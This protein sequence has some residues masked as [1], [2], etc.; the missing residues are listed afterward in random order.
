M[1]KAFKLSPAFKDVLWGGTALRDIYGM[2]IPTDTTGEAF[3]ASVVPGFVS[4]ADGEDFSKIANDKSLTGDGGFNLLFKLID[5]RQ[6]L[7]VQVHPN[8]EL[9]KKL[10][11]GRG[12][13]ECWYVLSAKEGAFLYLG[14]KEGV[15]KADLAES[16]KNGN[17]EDILCKVLVKPGDFFFVPAGTVHA[18]GEGLL[19][20]ELQQSC[21]TT[22]RVYDYNRRDKN[23]NTRPLHTE[24]ALLCASVAPYEQEKPAIICEGRERLCSCEYFSVERVKSPHATETA[25]EGYRMLFFEEGSAE[26]NVGGEKFTAEKGDT[27]FIP[28]HSGTFTVE[29]DATYLS[30]AE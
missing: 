16:A 12:K 30:M 20:A 4:M 25:D 26:I 8:D 9:A 19:I 11:N 21:D 23:G 7:S 29:G 28:A 17:M 22:Y 2:D 5:A 15:T 14:F 10:E 13:T 24:K 27:F 1:R 6:P 3:V 18:I